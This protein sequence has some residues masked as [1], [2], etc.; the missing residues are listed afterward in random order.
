MRLAEIFTSDMVLV[1]GKPIRIFGEGEGRAAV[2]LAGVT[3]EI[4][5]CAAFWCVEFAPMAWSCAQ[6]ETVLKHF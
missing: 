4:V 1:A 5:S 3:K 2:T 6:A